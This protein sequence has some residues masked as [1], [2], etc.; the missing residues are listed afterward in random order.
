MSA[1]AHDRGPTH[2]SDQ[3]LHI[4]HAVAATLKAVQAQAE[5]RAVLHQISRLSDRQLRDMGLDRDS[6][7]DRL[8]L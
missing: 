5:R 4:A 8:G 7:K 3:I 2:F 6:L 1:I